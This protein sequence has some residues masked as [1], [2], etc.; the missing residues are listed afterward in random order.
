MIVKRNDGYHVTSEK[1][2]NLGGP[3][4]SRAQAEKRLA[5]VEKFKHMKKG[6]VK[7]G[8][9]YVIIDDSK[10]TNLV[11]DLVKTSEGARKAWE[12]RRSGGSHRTERTPFRSDEPR[13][14]KEEEE[15]AKQPTWDSVQKEKDEI[16]G[17]A[18][19][20]GIETVDSS[21][22]TLSIEDPEKKAD[23]YEGRVSLKFNTPGSKAGEVPWTI[24][25][26]RDMMAKFQHIRDIAKEK[27]WK[28]EPR[29]LPH[30]QVRG[31]VIGTQKTGTQWVN[32]YYVTYLSKHALMSVVPKL[33]PRRKMQLDK[34]L[35]VV[36]D[37]RK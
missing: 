37:L 22:N 17:T 7:P 10:Y 32:T 35:Y 31:R 19:A 3:Y 8:V 1:G 20:H 4:K 2:K 5:Q 23:I 28:V 36:L 9:N 15:K 6:F 34:R 25:Q 13:F 24:E 11:P 30:V 26:H 21:Y 16:I 27:G 12:T 33:N 29:A 18:K 14:S